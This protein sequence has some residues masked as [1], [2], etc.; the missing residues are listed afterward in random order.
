VNPERWTHIDRLYHSAREQKPGERDR[1]LRQACAGDEELRRE[2]E[3]LLAYDAET[4]TLLDRPALEVVAG[5]LDAERRNRMIDRTLGRYKI[6]S[7]IGAGGMGEVYRAT[8]TRLG[9]AVAVKIL[10]QHL[11]THPDALARF[12]REAR[13]VAALSHPNI[14]AIHDFGD[15]EGIAY[16]VT[17]FLQGEALRARLDQSP[18]EWRKSVGIA[19]AVAAGLE[20]AHA[21]GITHRDLKPENIFLTED[22]RVKILDFGLAQ[23]GPVS[24]GEI[25][26]Q[27]VAKS[28][29]TEAGAVMGTVTYMSP[30][31]AEGKRVDP[32]SDVFSFGSVLYEM[33]TGRHAFQGETRMSTLAAILREEPQPIGKLAG[34]VPVRLEQIIRRCLRK[35][36]FQRY[37]SAHELLLELRALPAGP[38]SLTRRKTLRMGAVALAGLMLVFAWLLPQKWRDWLP[39]SAPRMASLAVLPL[40]NLSGD[41]TQE[42]FA[43]G[44]TD[45][46]IAD[47][48]QISSL[49]VISRM[50]VMQFKGT[51]KPLR[52]I[53]RQLNVDAIIN[54]SVLRSGDT[55]RITAELV[56]ISTERH[57][58]ART[59][60]RKVD[61]VLILQGEVAQAIAGEVKAR[62]TPQ[63][64][65]RLARSR[66][67]NPAALEA[68]L[69]GRYYWNQYTQ[70]PL[71]KSI[72]YFEEAI[73][74]EPG[75]ATAYAGL[76]LAWTALERI[77]AKPWQ[78]AYPKAREA[79]IKALE[80][81]DSLAEAHAAMAFAFD[82]NW[83]WKAS[84]AE[85]QKAT[86]LNPGY[87][88]PLFSRSTVL[89]HLG[90]T[91]ESIA[92]ARRA[93]ELDPLSMLANEV[94]ANAYMSAR[95]YDLAIAQYQKGLE[96]HP[97]DPSLQYLLG[98]AYVYKGEYAKG[99][100][101]IEKSLARDG[102]DPGLSP[103]LA[104]IDALIGKKEETR[105]I[106]ARLL[107]LAKRAPVNPG[108]IALVHTALGNREEALIL[109]EEA[110]RQHSPIMTWLKVDPRFDSIRQEPGFQELMRRVGLI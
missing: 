59:Y 67:V 20:A 85:A 40:A 110:F 23:I 49:R 44:M 78:E 14:L 103:D 9:R 34:R 41:T 82:C 17:E 58:W 10:S 39:H 63:E 73:R 97:D 96:L 91:E 35:D 46:L 25:P 43:D 8:D 90:R 94:M 7:W 108:L 66:T 19:I 15:Q 51:K 86:G 100:E 33:L 53:A 4:A 109:L 62:M 98:W 47:L 75:Y 54:G 93:L 83:D 71:L 79:A 102:M 28:A 92:V 68:Y 18:L 31:Q 64:E 104:Y 38:V 52:E 70:E 24:S 88:D 84:Q 101:A 2:I 56:D 107:V 81:D 60:E 42:Y 77:G 61:D 22:G 37:Q 74:L 65:R 48:A 16:A 27:A 69:K 87:A 105:K 36:P 72:E 99:I 5:A 21:K 106:L 89:R 12:E 32:R 29:L 6:E 80:I 3:S 45:V 13:A 76:S 50:S 55:V 95:R 30:E 57:L 1:F 11:A 26:S